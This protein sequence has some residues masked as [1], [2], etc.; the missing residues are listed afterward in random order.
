MWVIGAL[1]TDPM[2]SQRRTQQV[3]PLRSLRSA[4]V[5]MTK[6]LDGIARSRFICKRHK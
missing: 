4:P 3:P 2:Q 1:K 5:G 6:V